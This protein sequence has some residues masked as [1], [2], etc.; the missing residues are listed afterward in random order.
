MPSRM[1]CLSADG[2]APSATDAS[3]WR[4][5][6]RACSRRQHAAGAQNQPPGTTFDVAILDQ[7]GLGAGGLHAD[8]EAPHFAV[9]GEYILVRF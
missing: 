8:A 7:I 1:A 2:S 9:P 3:F 5:N 4:A 6:P